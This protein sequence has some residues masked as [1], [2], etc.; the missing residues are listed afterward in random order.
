MHGEEIVDEREAADAGEVRQAEVAE[1]EFGVLPVVVELDQ[2]LPLEQLVHLAGDH[3]LLDRFQPVLD[4]HAQAGLQ[5]RVV[6]ALQGQ[7][8]GVE[9]DLE[10]G[11][12]AEVPQE[13]EHGDGRVKGVNALGQGEDIPAQLCQLCCHFLRP[14]LASRLH[15]RPQGEVVGDGFLRVLV[16][17]GAAVQD[18]EGHEE[19][20]H[21]V[22][23]EHH[24]GGHEGGIFLLDDVPD[25][26]VEIAEERGKGESDQPSEG[27]VQ[28][29]LLLQLRDEAVGDRAHVVGQARAELL[30][31]L[32]GLAG[33]REDLLHLLHGDEVV[34][35]LLGVFQR[36]LDVPRVRAPRAAPCRTPARGRRPARA[37]GQGTRRRA[38][39]RTWPKGPASRNR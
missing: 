21:D 30:A 5:R 18:A 3:P 37:A 11:V 34:H 36:L 25:H 22:Q 13:I 39:A 15:P 33:L 20:L 32:L 2:P 31:D 19:L 7:T 9:H 28:P 17:R 4:L 35:G 16:V 23:R 10:P 6:E 27:K 8:R 12:L 14:A 38:S 24:G 1:I 29:G 26:A